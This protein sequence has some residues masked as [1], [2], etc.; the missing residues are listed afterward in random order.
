MKKTV[1]SAMAISALLMLASPTIHSA[2]Y[3]AGVF[4]NAGDMFAT[5]QPYGNFLDT[6]RFT[7]DTPT[8]DITIEGT[9]EGMYQGDLL[10]TNINTNEQYH[11]PEVF[12]ETFTL[13]AG[14]YIFALS[15]FA[16]NQIDPAVDSD[17][18]LTLNAVPLPAAMWLFGSALLGFIVYSR[19]SSV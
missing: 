1:F 10:L 18:D 6:Y 2:S 14:D 9:H 17:Y 11:L 16:L 4:L 12:S 15:G 8:L 13:T 3:D 5:Q 7:V 19:R